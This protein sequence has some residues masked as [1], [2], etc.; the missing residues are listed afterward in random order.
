MKL[1]QNGNPPYHPHEGDI[2]I[3]KDRMKTLVYTNGYWCILEDAHL[4]LDY[5]ERKKKDYVNESKSTGPTK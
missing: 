4:T 3:C 5:L 1:I 2:Y